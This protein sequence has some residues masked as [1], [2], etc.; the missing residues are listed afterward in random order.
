MSF[1]A[2]VAGVAL[3]LAIG[4]LLRR[5]Q[6]ERGLQGAGSQAQKLVKDAIAEGEARKKELLSEGKE[7]VNR[8]KTE[9]DRKSGNAR[10]NSRDRKGASNRR[11]KT[12]TASWNPFPGKK[13]N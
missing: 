8:L 13:R 5:Y 6:D 11:T 7:E 3:G 9:A 10:P 4:Y 2:L 1:I 12:W